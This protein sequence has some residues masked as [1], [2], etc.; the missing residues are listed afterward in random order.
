VWKVRIL[1]PAKDQR[2]GYL[3]RL[4]DGSEG[5]RMMYSEMLTRIA[6][7]CDTPIEE[8]IANDKAGELIYH[9]WV[10]NYQRGYSAMVEKIKALFA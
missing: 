5:S 3:P 4:L 8:I 9:Y 2:E 10:W 6:K 7:D 1:Q